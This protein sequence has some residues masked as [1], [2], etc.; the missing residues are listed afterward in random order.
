MK[1][2]IVIVSGL[3]VACALNLSVRAQESTNATVATVKKAAA[4]WNKD[5][6]KYEGLAKEAKDLASA[7]KMQESF[8]KTKE[9]EK[10]YDKG[11]KALKAADKKLWTKIDKQMDKVIKAAQSGDQTKTVAEADKF[12]VN[13]AEAGK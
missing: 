10:A 11:T 2:L 3:V 9:L 1:R 8:K 5:I 13:L 12:L 4:V 7:N 6:S